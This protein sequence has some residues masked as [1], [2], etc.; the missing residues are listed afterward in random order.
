MNMKWV[1]LIAFKYDIPECPNGKEHVAVDSKE[2]DFKDK[3]QNI[4]KCK[5][6]CFI[7]KW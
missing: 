2:N 6:A 7:W 4:M 1:S 5:I 3:L